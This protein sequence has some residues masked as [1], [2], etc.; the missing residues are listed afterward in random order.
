MTKDEIK[1]IVLLFK[2][3]RQS[4][5]KIAK[6]YKVSPPR[7]AQLIYRELGKKEVIQLKKERSVIKEEMVKILLNQK[8][9]KDKKFREHRKKYAL[10]R[11]YNKRYAKRN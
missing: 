5:V 10:N 6:I 2:F 9:K 3:D 4:F 1:K 8:Y 7:I 11:Y